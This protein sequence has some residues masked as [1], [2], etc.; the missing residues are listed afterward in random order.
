M[1]REKRYNDTQELQYLYD[2]ETQ[3]KESILLKKQNAWQKRD[4]NN[5]LTMLVLSLILLL[6]VGILFFISFYFYKYQKHK[7]LQIEAHN[8]ELEDANLFKTKLISIIAHD[9]R[10]PYT[11]LLGTLQLIREGALDTEEQQILFN[12]IEKQTN[13]TN[14]FINNL[15]LW[16]KAQHNAF[17][18]QPILFDIRILVRNVVELLKHQAEAK[19]AYL[20]SDVDEELYIY[21]DMEMLKIVIFNLVTNAIKFTPQQG[22]IHITQETEA[23]LAYIRIKDTGIGIS[24]ENQRKLLEK[25]NF[26]TSGT[27]G[28]SGFGLGLMICYDFVAMNNGKLSFESEAGKG[29]IF[30]ITLPTQKASD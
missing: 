7:N 28:E 10:R 20:G 22:N 3:E 9:L 11:N 16:A 27:A 18:F 4:L 29:S 17:K 2:F 8:H 12:E 6:F 26:Y 23:N 21:A 30:T 5:R 14:E 1:D 13:R 24:P 19:G 15:L 25:R